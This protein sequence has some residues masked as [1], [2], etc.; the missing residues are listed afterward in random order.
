M[1]F[2]PYSLQPILNDVAIDPTSPP[3]EVLSPSTSS[4]NLFSRQ[5]PTSSSAEAKSPPGSPQG[6]ASR[7]RGLAAA[8]KQG[9]EAV[10][11]W[12]M[13]TNILLP[14]FYKR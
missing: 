14:F 10:E 2:V 5:R 13:V 3:A 4:R 1:T 11:A 6:V 9:I 7:F 8:G 12:G